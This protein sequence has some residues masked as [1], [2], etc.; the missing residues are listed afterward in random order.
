MSSQI[1]SHSRDENS[2]DLLRVL[3]ALGLLALLASFDGADQPAASS[4]PVSTELTTQA[5]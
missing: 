2:A 1:N 3:L 4:P 5:E